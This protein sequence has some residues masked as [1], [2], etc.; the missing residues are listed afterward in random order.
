MAVQSS[1]PVPEQEQRLSCKEQLR[2]SSV[3]NLELM[4]LI[5]GRSG[6]GSRLDVLLMRNEA[7]VFFHSE[8]QIKKISGPKEGKTGWG[9]ARNWNKQRLG[10]GDVCA[11]RHKLSAR[12]KE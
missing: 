5:W 7:K 3:P 6:A 4:A 2:F 9:K 12:R 1:P 8:K 10:K 11:V